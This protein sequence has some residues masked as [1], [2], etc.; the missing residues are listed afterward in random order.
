ML[1]QG[2]CLTPMADDYKMPADGELQNYLDAIHAL[3]D[4][5]PPDVYGMHMNA[6]MT[7]GS[8][9]TESL[10]ADLLSLEGTSAVSMLGCALVSPP[11]LLVSRTHSLTPLFVVV[12]DA[13]HGRH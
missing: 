4:V 10:L 2:F 8:L 12:D 5:A 1:A 6:D 3:P 11:H 7:K 13:G 9:Q